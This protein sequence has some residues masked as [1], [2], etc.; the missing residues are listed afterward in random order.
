MR[1]LKEK[2]SS[3]SLLFAMVSIFVT[4]LL[5]IVFIPSLKL[6]FITSEIEE[7]K[8]AYLLQ[9]ETKGYLSTD[10]QND[11]IESVELVGSGSVESVII[12]TA[13]T[14]DSATGYGE[15]IILDFTVEFSST[16]YNFA[17]LF[18]VEAETEAITK[19]YYAESTSKN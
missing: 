10:D 3:D 17:S 15:R 5:M 16:S 7:V 19:H 2:G 12:N 18:N 6:L 11:L 4:A 9:M 1:K 13:T 14:T 8:R